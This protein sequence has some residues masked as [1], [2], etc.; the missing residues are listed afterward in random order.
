MVLSTFSSQCLLKQQTIRENRQSVNEDFIF[1]RAKRL[2]TRE[3]LP[4][5]V[6]LQRFPPMTAA[7]RTAAPYRQ[8][9]AD[10]FIYLTWLQLFD[11][12]YGIGFPRSAVTET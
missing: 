11:E 9:T 8:A 1:L 10:F 2:P 4:A 7:A 5:I 6:G 3:C 12:Q